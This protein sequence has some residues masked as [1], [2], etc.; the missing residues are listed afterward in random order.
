MESGLG[1]HM[2]MLGL[3]RGSIPAI[4]MM[5]SISVYSVFD[6]YFVSNFAGKTAFAAVNL[7]WPFAMVLGSLGF[8][9]GAGGAALVAKRFGEGKAE[10]ANRAFSNCFFFSVILGVVS[11]LASV[12]FLDSIARMLGAD[13]AMVPHCVAYGRLL[14]SGVTLFNIQNLFQSFFQAAEKQRLGFLITVLAG[15]T[16]IALDAILVAGCKMG[17]VG[18]GIGTIAGQGVGAI[19]P[20]LYFTLPNKSPLRLKFWRFDFPSIGRMA[21]NGA[22]EFLANISGSAVTILL[23]VKLMRAFGENGVD[24]YGIICY[25]WLIFA[26]VFIGINMSVAPRIS[27]AFGAG[28]K[29]ELKSLYGK[30]LN[31][32]L[33]FGLVQAGFSLSMTVPIAHAFAGYDAELF[34]ITKRANL[35]YSI[36]YLFLGFNMFGSAFFTALNNGAVSMA[37]SV[38]RLGVFEILAVLFIPEILGPEGIWWSIP[39]AEGLGLAMNLITMACFGKKY[40]YRGSDTQEVHG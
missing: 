10:E 3:L 7:I 33:I 39:I 27:Y 18:A 29:K 22:S 2:T 4:L 16:N 23:N 12:F 36:V 20:I 31:L 13:E 5:V 11:T 30:A 38:A 19:I 32:L 24:A 14:I 1:K 21:S 25:V 26:A 6:G 40:G 35:I 34:A 8:M 37:L 28:D 15:V 9:M 17:I